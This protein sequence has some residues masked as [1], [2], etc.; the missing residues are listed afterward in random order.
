MSQILQ[1]VYA[2]APVDEIQHHTLELL[3]PAIDG[4]AIRIVLGDEDLIATTENDETLTFERGAFALNL[5]SKAVKGRQDLQFQVDNVSG[6]ALGIVLDIIEAGGEATAIY[7]LYLDS[8]LSAPAERPIVMTAVGF[9]INKTTF[10]FTASFH[11]LVNKAWPYRRYTPEF[12]PGLKYF[13][14]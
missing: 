12:A 3:H 9:Y 11:D 14:S 7:R 1:T 6:R 10:S 2:S 13:G 5:P 4:G 8:D